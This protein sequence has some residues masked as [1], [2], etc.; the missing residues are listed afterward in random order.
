LD[1]Q[2]CEDC[3]QERKI[4][5]LTK[6]DF[7]RE[8]QEIEQGQTYRYLGIEESEVILHQQMKENLKKEYT[9]ILRILTKSKLNAINTITAIQA[10]V[11]PVLRY[12]F[13]IIKWRLEEIR[14]IDM[15]T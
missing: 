5:S 2:V 15:K 8:T 12:S 9:R 4:S 7:N 10:L 14:K 1:L 3:T 13:G 11:I 6:F